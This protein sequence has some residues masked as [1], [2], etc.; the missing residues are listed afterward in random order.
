[1]QTKLLEIL[2]KLNKIRN[3]IFD[4]LRFFRKKYFIIKKKQIIFFFKYYKKIENI[5]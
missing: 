3:N 5:F 4:F 2:E 1:M